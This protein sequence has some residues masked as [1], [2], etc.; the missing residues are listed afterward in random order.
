M[1][2]EEANARRANLQKKSTENENNVDLAEED[3]TDFDGPKCERLE[4]VLGDEIDNA[5]DPNTTLNNETTPIRTT[6]IKFAVKQQDQP[7]PSNQN[8]T[9][10]NN[11]L[12]DS[13]QSSAR[14]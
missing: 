6:S 7:Q 1:L 9:T 3:N 11:S 8:S 13:L 2:I 14:S 10:V 12:F 5:N 4:N